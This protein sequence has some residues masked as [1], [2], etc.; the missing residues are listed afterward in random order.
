MCQVL[1]K[2]EAE[3]L[4]SLPPPQRVRIPMKP[5]EHTERTVVGEE[6]MQSAGQLPQL[7][8][9]IA[10][11][12][13]EQL[14]WNEYIDRYHYLGYTPLTGAQMKY[15]VYAGDDPVALLGFGSAA[16]RVA[17]RDWYI[18]WGEEKRK[19]NL[20]LI[21][22]NARFLILPWVFSK[23]LASM[24]LSMVAKRI[25][26]DWQKRYKYCPVLLETFVE[27][28]RFSGTCYKAANWVN[29]GTTQGRG[30][31]DRFNKARL[32]KKDIFVF[33]MDKDYHNLLC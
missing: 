29:V 26:T 6:I 8:I 9:E 14:L 25:P 21:L 24:V 20:H 12:S 28:N 33:P 13:D 32:P 4:V 3:A 17:P 30:R 16:W 7:H 1:V 18:G 31:G 5:I 15:F 22:N 19:E 23:N 11:S 27:K 2:M 10:K